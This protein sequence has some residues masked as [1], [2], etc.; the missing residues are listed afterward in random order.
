M[1]KSATYDQVASMLRQPGRIG[2]RDDLELVRLASLAASSHNTQPWRFR[3][4]ERSISIQPDRTRQC[5][6]VDPE[7]AHL[8]RS[9]GCAAEN[10]V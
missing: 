6:A 10:L 8:Y 5:P 7:G 9:L 1:F 2:D 4:G 3:I